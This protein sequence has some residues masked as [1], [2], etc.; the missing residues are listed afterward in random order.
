MIFI[1]NL[2]III[3]S[4][5]FLLAP[6]KNLYKRCV[7]LRTRVLLR[8]QLQSLRALRYR[9]K[10]VV[11]VCCDGRFS[12]FAPF[13]AV[14]PRLRAACPRCNAME[15]Q[16]FFYYYIKNHTDW[17]QKVNQKKWEVLH[18]A[19]EICLS[20]RFEQ[21]RNWTYHTADI[22]AGI[23]NETMDIQAI[24]YPDDTFDLIFVAHVT[25]YI[26]E[27]AKA[28]QELRR[29]LKPTGVLVQ[30]TRIFHAI[31]QSFSGGEIDTSARETLYGLDP[32]VRW[33]HGTDYAE[34]LENNGFT[35]TPVSWHDVVDKATADR[36]GF[37]TSVT[38]S[39]GETLWLCQKK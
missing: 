27:E 11:C 37:T 12:G 23:A 26:D 18:F 33:V 1:Y 34:I 6:I 17:L 10:A 4:I 16:R 28:L 31:K 20:Q 8:H 32:Y 30:S 35:V 25:S 5:S 39:D 19:P 21:Q 22:L 3:S 2:F 14:T 36:F 13:G 29:V 9:G 38:D 15:R 24:P 7:S